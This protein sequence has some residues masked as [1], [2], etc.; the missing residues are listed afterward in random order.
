MKKY[1]IIGMAA[2]ALP[3]MAQET[4]DNAQLSTTD[5][6]GT[7]RYIGMGGALEA[8]GA[9]ITTMNTNPAGVGMIRRS[10]M[11]ISAGLTAQSGDDPASLGLK[12]RNG[13]ATN[14]DFNQIGFVY[15]TQTG[16]NSFLNM[17]INYH[18]S[19]NFNQ[20]ITATN[21]LSDASISKRA[22]MG[23]ASWIGGS[24]FDL[25]KEKD[26]R[27]YHTSLMDNVIDNVL[28]SSLVRML[29]NNGEIWYYDGYLGSN[30]YATNI[31]NSGYVNDFDFNLSGNSKNRLFWGVTIGLKDIRYKSTTVYD[32]IISDAEGTDA[33]DMYFDSYRRISGSGINVK[34]GIIYRPF[35]EDPFRIGLYLNT[36]TWYSLSCEGSMSASA[37]T[38]YYGINQEVRPVGFSY[39]YKMSTPWK[40]GLSLGTTM[41]SNLALGLTYEYSDYGGI[42]NR[43]NE[44]DYYVESFDGYYGYTSYFNNSSVD[45]AMNDNTKASLK[46]VHLIKLGAEYKPVP[47]VALR[48]GYNYQSP[49]YNE[50]G[51]KDLMIDPSLDYGSVG[52]YYTTYDYINWKATNRVTFGLGFALSNHVNL[53]LSYQYATQKGDYHPFESTTIDT[54]IN[55]DKGNHALYNQNPE[56]GSETYV[57]TTLYGTPSTVKNNRHQL[58]ATLSYRF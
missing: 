18:R 37:Y 40:F 23:L 28:N 1:I 24:D 43:I 22:F 50:N 57:P 12:Y 26:P 27:T 48:L 47:T 39:K 52:N 46:G 3:V 34:A 16:Q 44:G 8:L 58:N 29:D 2:L 36:P 49:I 38:D 53:D 21:R 35:E 5:L 9:D 17:G 54:Y 20:V 42:S 11:G 33:G 30:A 32:E 15:S 45:R 25:A 41:G 56:I 10:W 6:N 55:S 19:R 4:Y 13:K 7:A 14:A 51:S 31:E